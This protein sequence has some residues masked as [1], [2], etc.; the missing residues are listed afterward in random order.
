MLKVSKV[1]RYRAI[2]DE[3]GQEI[4]AGIYAKGER[5]PP[6]SELAKRF[7][8]SRLTVMRALREL[9]AGAVVQ[10]RAG[11]GTFVAEIDVPGSADNATQ[12]FGLLMPDLG[13]G[14]IFEP[15]ARAIA[16]AGEL[17]HHRLL[18][19]SEPSNGHDKEQQA[20]ELCRYLIGRK[21]AGV[22]FAP[23]EHTENQDAVNSA[24]A[25]ELSAAGIPIVLIDRCIYRYPDRSK[26]D[27][28][29][30]DNVR[31]GHRMT[32]H[33]VDAG[34][35]RVV[36]ASRPGSA[37]TVE[38]RHSGYFEA[39]R[40]A[41]KPS[42]PTLRLELHA[43]HRAHLRE[44]LETVRPDGIV[45]ANDLTAATLMHDLLKLGV[46]IPED[47]RMVGINDVKYASFLSVPLTTLRQPCDELGS[48][49]M[50]LMLD[51]QLRPDAPARDVLLNCELIVRQ[52]CGTAS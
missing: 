33:L 4:A 25:D 19:G 5:L 17:L 26:F 37:P 34:C 22:F 32:R 49:A 48:A 43:D 7:S 50:A 11:S 16:R 21:V 41:D 28:V 24:I 47:V 27:L 14:E 38:A 29:G 51:R 45:C 30:I 52:S 18:W 31:A 13:D 20:Q 40:A 3:I 44:F 2:S 15:V 42:L 46:R 9:E 23:V 35:T 39:L 6:D 8:V 12:V 1:I 36:F 10:R